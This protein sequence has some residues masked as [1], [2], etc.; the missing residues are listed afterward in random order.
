MASDEK[1]PTPIRTDGTADFF[2]AAKHGE[3]MLQ[4]CG[5]CDQFSFT[6]YKYCPNCYAT[7][8]WRHS[9]GIA[10]VKSFAIVTESG[11]IGFRSLL[12]YAVAKAV[13]D[14]GPTLSLRYD[15]DV[16]NIAIGQKVKVA[17]AD[18]ESNEATPVWVAQ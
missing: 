15:G 13:L 5:K 9:E 2:E 8:E 11:H 18:S 3:F 6:G 17:F 12:P 1:R 16:G 10:I 14:D 4:H 7:T